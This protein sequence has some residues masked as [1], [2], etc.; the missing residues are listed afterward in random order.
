MDGRNGLFQDGFLAKIEVFFYFQDEWEGVSE[1]LR[2][3]VGGLFEGTSE[4]G[5]GEIAGGV[6][7]EALGVLVEGDHADVVE[8]EALEDVLKVDGFIGFHGYLEEWEEACHAPPY[9]HA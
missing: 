3:E 7:E 2:G 5:G 6:E 9:T 4:G 8:R 1:A